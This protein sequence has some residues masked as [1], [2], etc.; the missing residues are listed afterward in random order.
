MAASEV[1]YVGSTMEVERMST[2]NEFQ[3]SGEEE[4]CP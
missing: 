2:F 4:V 3:M 1:I